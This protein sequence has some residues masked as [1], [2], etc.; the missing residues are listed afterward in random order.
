MASGGDAPAP[1]SV[2]STAHDAIVAVAKR[3]NVETSTLS[4]TVSR[5]VLPE[6]VSFQTLSSLHSAAKDANSIV[7]SYDF[8][9]TS[10]SELVFSVK[11]NLHIGSNASATATAS[12]SGG[13]GSGK[14]KRDIA[15]T[16]CLQVQNAIRKV[17]VGAGTIPQ[18]E[19]DIA[20]TVLTR[21]VRDLRGPN[22]E[23]LVESFGV[24]VRKL[25]E[26]DARAS[27]VLAVR[28]NS[29][30]AVPVSQLKSALGL[31]WQDGVV[32]SQSSVMGILQTDLPLTDEGNASLLQGNSP[33]LI[34][35]AVPKSVGNG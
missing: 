24:F 6:T 19:I 28:I 1:T 29:G 31:C 20:E 21:V 9:A 11:F 26:Q 7:R 15:D 22:G 12:G 34:V 23:L 2:P 17:N 8:V 5:H 10:G 27:L 4:G 3:H 18:S 13:G 30:L 14:R 25:Q 32:S 35:T 33:M 16:H